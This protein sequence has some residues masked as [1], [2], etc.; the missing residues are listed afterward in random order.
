[1]FNFSRENTGIFAKWWRNVDRQILFL[2]L[3]LFLL[4]LFFSFSSTSSIVAEK[5][6]KET[7]FFFLRHLLFVVISLILLIGIS[8][9]K[10]NKIIPISEYTLDPSDTNI[11][12]EPKMY[13][14]HQM[15]NHH[16]NQ[17]NFPKEKQNQILCSQIPIHC[18]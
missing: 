5:M 13:T 17:R 16:R 2:F 18:F 9:Q 4:G 1:M 12:N 14:I 3:F 8:I 7:Y 11:C 15:L 6:N 10:R